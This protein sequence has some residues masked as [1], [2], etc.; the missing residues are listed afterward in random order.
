MDPLDSSAAKRVVPLMPVM[1]VVLFVV[2]LVARIVP[3]VVPLVARMVIM[4]VVLLEVLLEL[5]L[6]E[7]LL[8]NVMFVS[9]LPTIVIEVGAFKR[10]VST[11]VRLYV[12]IDERVFTHSC[13]LGC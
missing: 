11:S 3:L 7:L 6:A 9:G 12:G 4:V 13:N 5:L 10:V 2:P 8:W 1:L